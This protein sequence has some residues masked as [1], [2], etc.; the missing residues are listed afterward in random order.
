MQLVGEC[1]ARLE[2]LD[3]Q[4]SWRSQEF[5]GGAKRILKEIADV[6]DG[7]RGG[8]GTLAELDPDT[9]TEADTETAAMAGSFWEENP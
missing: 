8:K 6:L 2:L 7:F 4:V 3:R 1:G 9:E 5:R